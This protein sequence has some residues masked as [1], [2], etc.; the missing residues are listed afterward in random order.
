VVE[1]RRCQ[2][3]G[4]ALPAGAPQ[5]LCPRCLLGTALDLGV[6]DAQLNQVR[7]AAAL[8]QNPVDGIRRFGDYELLE[9]I[10]HGGMGVVYRARRVSL[11]RAVA[12]KM[13]LFGEFAS[14]DLV[15]RFR[16]EAAAAAGLHHQNIVAIHEVGECDGR[17]FFS[18]DLVAGKS[19]AELVRDQPLPPRRAA[20]Y[21]KAIAMAI[22]YAH[23]QGVLHRDLKPSNVLIDEHDQPRIT[24]FGLAKRLDPGNEITPSGQVL[25]SPSYLSP[26][27]AAGKRGEVGVHSD[28]YC[29]GALL[30]HLLT[31]R[32]PFVGETIPQTLDQVLHNDPVSPRLLNPSVPRDL[33]TICL[34]CLE[35]DPPR[36][37]A[38]AQGLADDLNRFLNRE[39]IR[40]RPLGIPFKL[41]RWCRRK[42]ALAG[43]FGLLVVLAAGAIWAALHF[44]R[45][46]EELRRTGYVLAIK[47]A[48]TQLEEGNTVGAERLLKDQLPRAG[49]SNLRGFEW[50]YLCSR[51]RGNYSFSLP[52]HAQ[53]AGAIQ[54]AHDT[55]QVAVYTWNGRLS[56][57]DLLG[58]KNL[59][60]AN[61]SGFGGFSA[62]GHTLVYGS[63]RRSLEEFEVGSSVPRRQIPVRGDL[64]ALASA[65]RVAVTVDREHGLA[66]V[67]LD[68]GKPR[69]L[70]PGFRRSRTDY[71][72]G[73]PG[74][75]S[76]DGTTLALVE[77]DQNPLRPDR[78]IH[79]WDV[80]SQKE[81]CSL[82]MDREVRSLAFSP[83]GKVLAVGD[84]Q[85]FLL[86]YDRSAPGAPPVS[87]RAHGLPVLSL[88][89]SPDGEKLATGSS[90]E[91]PILLWNVTDAAPLSRHFTGQVGDVWSLAFSADGKLLASGTRDGL[92]RFWNLTEP[93]PEETIK[94]HVYAHEYGNLV[95]SAD[96]QW[97][98]AGCEGD[99]VKIWA[100][101]NLRLRTVLTNATYV[102]AFSPDS[103]RLLVST[104]GGS[105]HWEDLENPGSRPVPPYKGAV[106]ILS[107]VS[108]TADHQVAAVGSRTGSIEIL[109]IDS[110]RPMG[111][112]FSHH[113][114]AVLSLAFS[115]TADKLVS[116]GNDKQIMVSD[117]KT[118][119]VLGRSFEHKGGV[120]AIAI[121]PDGKTL[122]SACGA[123][124][125]KFWDLTH[126]DLAA[127]ADS[128][129]YHKSLV[130]T[131][132][133][134]PDGMTLA[135][136]SEDHSVRLWSVSLHAEVACFRCDSPV[137]LVLFSPD[138]NTLASVT[139]EGEVRLFRAL[140]LQEANEALRN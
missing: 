102:V 118:G 122:A 44:H 25:G 132:A 77:P 20:S 79:I 1:T 58:R 100:V 28:V 69:L 11:N 91:T 105:P 87:R 119:A 16:A 131:L 88:A 86:L 71:G 96:S 4:A 98:A 82:L 42:P 103:R 129:S 53:V 19:L 70:V 126:P 38:S 139:D 14:D 138:G 48:S 140:G 55:S 120:C 89:F 75:I 84:G 124:T 41:A 125:L 12:V 8:Q 107:A 34:K 109:D 136:G 46:Q 40:A 68:D 128:L 13:L 7:P 37:Y 94:D 27:Q 6:A 2:E 115:P 66:V 135:S 117:V 81:L 130:R 57:W 29:L 21:L 64:V 26:E 18:M 31:G 52:S 110:G 108:L 101:A 114:G 133:F 76:A 61:V 3:C 92:V 104:R 15:E 43:V 106:E 63:G 65:A 121:S 17:H 137:R 80:T 72:W 24:D 74:A 47:R 78:A 111:G 36:R 99:V 45:M 9:E 97:M 134:S 67:D 10:A 116:G 56:V 85:G 73:F 90:D 50:R 60:Q 51:C 49:Q 95:F 123:G 39:P 127:A 54:F 30:Y 32:P 22:H 62:N 35:K 59:F 33:E 23:Q 93:V 83:N 112:P 113:L 5:G